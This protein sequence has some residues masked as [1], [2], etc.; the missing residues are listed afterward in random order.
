[1]T[2]WSWTNRKKKEELAVLA[3]E[4]LGK[5]ATDAAIA[6]LEQGSKKGGTAVKQS[7]TQAL[8]QIQKQRRNPP[9]AI[10]S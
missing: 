1:L 4:T 2:E 3:A 7:C 8:A 6:A 5:L 10:A 9:T